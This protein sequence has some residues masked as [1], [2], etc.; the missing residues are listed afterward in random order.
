MHSLEI[1]HRIVRL[2]S[3]NV[4]RISNSEQPELSERAPLLRA[5]NSRS[6]NWTYGTLRVE[7][8]PVV[9]LLRE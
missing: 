1:R 3:R 7:L 8:L 4:V 6:R 5:M 2:L 9:R